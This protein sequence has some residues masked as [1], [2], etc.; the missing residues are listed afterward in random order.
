[1]GSVGFQLELSWGEHH[2]AGDGRDAAP[3]LGFS[4]GT[5]S[6]A[7]AA[8]QQVTG[9]GGVWQ[10][11]LGGQEGLLALLQLGHVL[12]WWVPLPGTS[13]SRAEMSPDSGVLH[14][15]QDPHPTASWRYL[16]SV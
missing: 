7:E 1:M 9:A 4:R 13:P 15:P 14:Q 11:L 3:A 12:S 6:R 16:H 10:V 2:G 5:L 8:P